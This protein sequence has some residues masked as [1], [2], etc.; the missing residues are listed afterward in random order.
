MMIKEDLGMTD[1]VAPG[2]G[3]TAEVKLLQTELEEA[4]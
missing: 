3:Q 4:E 1:V 2:E